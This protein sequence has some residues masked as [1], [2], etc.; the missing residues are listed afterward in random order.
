MRVG[1][2][3]MRGARGGY[4]R[5][6]PSRAVAVGSVVACAAVSALL[7][8]CGERAE[9]GAEW[10]SIAERDPTP[11]RAVIATVVK[12]EEGR[13]GTWLTEQRK[14]APEFASTAAASRATVELI[15]AYRPG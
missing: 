8:A 9:G 12:R 11:A 2:L 3:P 5:R 4:D 13:L 14:E 15:D 10:R 6:M 7:L 1:S